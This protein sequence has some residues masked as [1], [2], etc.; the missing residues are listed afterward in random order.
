[1]SLR[2]TCS[3]VCLFLVVIVGQ[4]FLPNSVSGKTLI[5]PGP[6]RR[7]HVSASE[8]MVSHRLRYDLAVLLREDVTDRLVGGHAPTHLFP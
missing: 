3:G 1:V 6:T 5:D 7:G 2:T 4:A 8:L